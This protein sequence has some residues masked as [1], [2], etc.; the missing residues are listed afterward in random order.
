VSQ[1]KKRQIIEKV[2]CRWDTAKDA[3]CLYMVME[4]LPGGELFSYFRTVRK[5]PSQTV[6]FYAAEILLALEYLHSIHIV[7]EPVNQSNHHILSI[8]NSQAYR[9]LKPENL[10]VSLHGHIKL[11][12][13][14]FAKVI[15]NK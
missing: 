13:F 3:S 5:F 4:F 7:S 12:D 15:H 6:K 10:M 2:N 9:D 8:P 11:T 14:G 1:K